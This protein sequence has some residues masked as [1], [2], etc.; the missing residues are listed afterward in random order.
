MRYSRRD[1]VKI[2]AGAGAGLLLGWKPTFAQEPMLNTKPIPS[3]GERI[4]TVGLGAR[5]YRIGEGWDPDKSGFYATIQKFHELGGKLID[6]APSYGP[7]ELILGEIMDELGIRDDLFVATKVDREGRDEGITRMGRSM[8]R[9]RTDRVELMQVHNLR[10]WETHLPVLREW[11]EAGR[12]KYLG[13]TTSNARAYER[14]ERIMQQEELDF[15]Q[16]DYAVDRRA[17]AERILPLA[18]DRGMAV[19]INL[20]F[21]RGRLFRRTAGRELPEWSSEFDCS[22]WA[23]FFLKYVVSHPAVTCAI[24][25]TTTPQHCIDNLGAATGRLPTPEMRRR[26]EEHIDAMPEPPSGR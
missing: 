9:L 19:I 22:S 7:S 21:G 16:V 23:Q 11:K 3:S 12:I 2:G 6:T 10:D 13:V 4:P 24:P 5:N 17:S 15:V 1:V 25:G 18:A 8:G 26:M 20:A 14:L